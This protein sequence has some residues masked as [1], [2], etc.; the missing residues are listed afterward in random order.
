MAGRRFLA[1][2]LAVCAL[3]G[4]LR[5]WHL[6]SIHGTPFYDFDAT[7]A[8]SDMNANLSWAH[9]V[10][11]GDW[12]DRNAWRPHFTWQ[13]NVADAETWERWLGPSTYY[14]PP[15]Y[16]YLVALSIR[17]TGGVDA[18]RFLQTL[19]GAVNILLVGLLARRFFGPAAGIVAALF[20][21][22]YAPFIL[23][24]SELLRGTLV[25]TLNTAALLALSATPV[26]ESRGR[27]ILAGA[28][29]GAAYLCDSAVITFLPLA[30]IWAIW[31]RPGAPAGRG[32]EAAW[33]AAGLAA[34]L[35]PLVA[36]NLVV[37]AP[38]LSSTTRAPLAFVMGNA[39]DSRPVGAVIPQGTEEILKASDYKVLGTILATIGAYH[40]AIGDL[41]LKQWEKL[42]GL[43]NA[44]EV[45]D[46]PSF[47]YA[48]LHSPVLTWGLRFSC[49]GG[50][51]LAGMLLAARR[52]RESSLL[53]LYLASV[54][55]LFLLAHVVSRYRQPLV[56]P[57][58]IFAGLA[59][60]EGARALAARR[61]GA[62]AAVLG[63][64]TALSFALPSTPPPGYRYYRPSEF[65][66]AADALEQKGEVTLASKELRQAL[67]LANGENVP[68]TER[69]KLNLAL[70]ELFL[71]HER[72]PEALSAFR[73]VLDDEGDNAE[74]LIAV[75]GIHHDTNQPMEAL[76]TLMRAEQVSPDNAEV[77]ARLGHLLWVT[78][79]DGA[80]ALPHLRKA[81]D[82]APNSPAAADLSAW[83]TQAGAASG[84]T[85]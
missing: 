53:Y 6:S 14:Q 5:L 2:L 55:A 80:A 8:S 83:A 51:G 58:A 15:L 71:R 77:E 10:A 20:V 60:T 70:G 7:W 37:G 56:I 68:D 72:Y 34:A 26:K 18:W 73:D 74:A 30:F 1:T 76:S 50:L 41:A 24:D 16:T 79:H 52:A 33:I 4:A 13:D 42:S 40:G 84:K 43:W 59:L 36:R 22:G 31:I 64:A 32:R 81:L 66:I 21:A 35:L 82:L 17:G 48:A 65:V 45:P 39:P 3:G 62:A 12:L 63:G 27:C 28:L 9:H 69:V 75:G 54:L 61:W 29:L 38:I 67:A 44:Y 57:L 19:L 78:F 23:Y 25:I 49:V 46:N 85:P 47:Y 11:S